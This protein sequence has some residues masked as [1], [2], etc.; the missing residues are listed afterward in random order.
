[1]SIKVNVNPI[2]KVNHLVNENEIKGIYVFYGK[3]DKLN[4]LFKRDS[5]NDAFIDK[6]TGKPIFNAEEMQNIKEKDIPVHFSQQQIH[7]DDSIATIK[8]KLVLE[9]SNTF[10]YEEIYLFCMKEETFNP[11]LIYQTLTQNKRLEL[12]RGRL[13]HFLL[14]IIRNNDGSEV[15]FNVPDKEIYDYDDILALRLDDKKCWV[16]KVLGQKFF[17]ITNEYPFVVNPFD[18]LE[19]DSFLEQTAR[20]SLSTLNNNLLL[21]TGIIVENNLYLC[22]AQDVL[23]EK[24]DLSQYIMKIYYPFLYAKNIISLKDIHAKTLELIQENK[25]LLQKT[26]IDTFQSVDMFYDI[27]RERKTELAYKNTG[28]KKIRAIL[29]PEYNIKIPL[30]VIF[31]LIH[32]TEGNPLIKYNP[33]SRKEQIYRLYADKISKDGRKI[34]FLSRA[35]IFKLMKK[36]GKNRSVAVYIDYN[37]DDTFYSFVCEFQENGNIEI[38]G[39]FEKLLSVSELNDTIKE[40]INPIIDV[41]KTYLEQSGYSIHLFDDI[42]N[43]NFEVK[44]L[45]YESTIGINEFI[46]LDKWRGCLSAAFII[47][48]LKANQ[49]IEMRFKRVSNFN[50]ITSQ[51]AFILEKKDE[52]LKGDE[53]IDELVKVY[54]TSRSE[55]AELLAKMA[56]ELEVQRN[57]KRN[58]ISIKINPGFKT[59][60]HLDKI[61]SEI[62]IRVENINDIFYL[63]T[64][65]VYLDSLVRLTQGDLSDTTSYPE[66]Q[67]KKICSS[68]KEKKDV[69]INDFVA[70]FEAR[71]EEQEV[72]EFSGDKLVFKP[73]DQ[74]IEDDSSDESK[75]QNAISIFYGDDEEDEEEN[76]E[77]GK[78][79]DESSEKSLSSLE[80]EKSL[81]SLEAAPAAVEEEKEEEES[82]KSLSSLEA[83]PAAVEEESEKSLSSLE[84]APAAVEEESE[85]SL[86]SLEAAPAA[87]EEESEKSLSSLEA[88]PAAEEEEKEEEIIAPVVKKP[89]TAKLISNPKLKLEL[90]S[91]E[92][93]EEEDKEEE[94]KTDV[95]PVQLY[96]AV[97]S[98]RDINNM[99]LRNYFQN[100]IAEKEP[101]LILKEKQ[102][103]YNAYSRV[104][105]SA[106]RRQPIILTKEELDKINDENPGFLKDE[107]VVNYGSTEDKNY[108]YVCPRYWNL[109]T[110]TIVTPAQME[111]DK[112]YK[113]IIPQKGKDSKNAT[114]EKYIYEFSP[115]GNT[116][117]DFKQ[118]PSF[119]VNK[120]PD[121]LCLPCC[122]TNWN[123]P[124]QIK[125]REVCSGEK[126]EKGLE[127]KEKPKQE[128]E[129]VKGPEK[130][131]LDAGRWGFLPIQIQKFL[132]EASSDCQI[133]KT[134]TN[135]KLNHPCLLRHG[136]EISSSQSFIACIADAVFFTKNDVTSK[137]VMKSDTIKKMKKLLI[138][139]LNL[140]NFITY[141]NGNLVTDFAEP[142]REI[143][144]S[145]TKYTSSKLYTKISA[146]N[147][148]DVAYFKK[149]CSAYENFVAFLKDDKVFIDY[150][151]LWDM[152]CKP[153]E[154][155]FPNGINLVILEIPDSDIT[156][157]VDLICPTNHYS[158]EIYEAR[159]P[160]LIL[161]RR[162]D[163][164]EPIYSYRNTEKALFIGKLFSEFDP[165]LS[166][167]MRAV[168]NKLI[169]PYFQRVCQPLS[170]L[171]ENIYKAKR[172]LI[173]SNMIEILSK[174]KY[175][176]INQVVNYQNKVIGVIAEKTKRG[177]IPC[178]PSA[179]NNSFDYV[180]MIDPSIWSEY[181]DTIEFLF[182]V[183][184]D[185]KEAIACKPAFKIVEDEMI[186]GI[187]T[188]TNQFVQLSK[189]FSLGDTRDD[190][191]V[192]E[193]NNYIVDKNK[194]PMISID[195]PIATSHDVDRE[196]VD[197]IKKIKLETNFYNVFRNTIRIL[198]NDYE[199]IKLRESIDEEISKPYVIYSQKLEKIHEYLKTL[200][201]DSIVFSDDYDYRIISEVSTCIVNRNEEKCQARSPLCAF[202]SSNKC[203]IILPKKN[204]TTGSDNE[205]FYFGKMSDEL[206]RYSRIKSFILEPQSY[207]SFSNVNYNLNEDEII[208]IQSMLTPEYFEGLTP[209]ILNKYVKYNSY[210]EVEPMIHPVYDNTFTLEDAMNATNAKSLNDCE[211][212][213]SDKIFSLIWRKKFP[214]NFREK[215]Y[216][217]TIYCTFNLMIDL[218]KERTGKMFDV[219]SIREELYSEYAKYVPRLEGQILD[220]M[221]SQGKKIL[222]GQVK[223]KKLSFQNLILSESY[224]LTTIDY[225]VLANKFQ[226]P[227]FFISGKFLFE[228]NFTKHEFLAYGNAGDEFCFIV[229]PGLRAEEIPIFKLIQSSDNKIFFKLE[230]IKNDAELIIAL[231]EKVSPEQFISSFSKTSTYVYQKKK[232][233]VVL[234]VEEEEETKQL[235]PPVEKV[236]LESPYA[237][238]KKRRTL[239]EK[240][241]V[242]KRKTKKV[243]PAP[244][245]ELTGSTE[246]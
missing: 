171:P 5:E 110:N 167:T 184:K 73:L 155:L 221:I 237:A 136:V 186:V 168:F 9:F 224:Y 42:N 10:S 18:V 46:K 160:T 29:R 241:I 194:E 22:L 27:F 95:A 84:A 124:D 143:N 201:G 122:F 21:N 243:V 216:S 38:T 173:L 157:N 232:P 45:D 244:L 115:P 170:S 158:R 121:G 231:E 56:S 203:Q 54:Q 200:A 17:I 24:A 40:S 93:N 92:E 177:F 90:D 8:L 137:D 35:A 25:K 39:E 108:Y 123:T 208:M 166:A 226:I 16:N 26:T 126:K 96:R 48:T 2:Y 191:P 49:N 52:G 61:K 65:P 116:D 153:N 64:I 198:L 23:K 179:I 37:K 11:V 88:A 67:I 152:I 164:F 140:D 103:K 112:L 217:K 62:T 183:S 187:L 85:K 68:S 150:T 125:R 151:Y 71:L 69:T 113:H 28:V 66:A 161:L 162:G 188:Q 190:I 106:D 82:E 101:T 180:F 181:T 227:L 205:L 89:P 139:I 32:A 74:Y 128:E 230:D 138:S 6:S 225:Y 210:D 33:S 199:N 134:N 57:V 146:K 109:K 154:Y 98:V 91:E 234:E 214:K 105:P 14:N 135:I 213:T 75:V 182:A 189:P 145:K 236:A 47:D 129:Y 50:K 141:Q 142:M 195:A 63:T 87:V 209:A 117:K 147:K 94:K 70:A 192:L 111:R 31:K 144:V 100:K 175:T 229:V 185:T 233:K 238:P 228:T 193:N 120:H 156:N 41:V 197:Y 132:H 76:L 3:N 169:K 165:Q 7:F 242:D 43:S 30:D 218:I 174:K 176:I 53:I 102:G 19:H 127:E 219:N 118:Y 202:T 149:V 72:P 245:L 246:A 148:Y 97:N 78:V 178:Y 119:Q 83:A 1:M 104:C 159:K 13:D 215:V 107:D 20:K 58:E 79:K 59:S 15:D 55:A 99:P 77:G 36:I 240:K 211:T 212:T 239:K 34:P 44:N 204:L 86:S 206:I 131:P 207:L 172:P 130:F 235:E 163:Y 196:R 4:E 12:T 220:I 114:N 60:I 133:S 51:E 223:A 80:S 222:A 81:S